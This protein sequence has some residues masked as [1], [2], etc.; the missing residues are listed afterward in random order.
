MESTLL[1]TR[2]LGPMIVI[3]GIGILVN[4]KTYQ[5]VM[6]D[7]FK[8]AALVYLGG[9]LALVVGILI[10]LFHNVWEANWTIIITIFGWLGIVKGVCLIVFPNMLN[11]LTEAYAKNATLLMV[12]SIIIIAFGAFF[13][14]KGYLAA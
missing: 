6:E 12:H 4:L 1:I 9:V 7:F 5:K 13:V 3:I 14:F 11:K 10:V 8:N 2:I